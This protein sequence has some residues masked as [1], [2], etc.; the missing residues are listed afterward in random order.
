MSGMSNILCFRTHSTG[1]SI[2]PL[3]RVILL[4]IILS[5]V[6]VLTNTAYPSTA[7]AASS[8]TAILTY[9]YDISR[10]GQNPNETILNTSNVNA[11]Q[12]G[13]RVSYPV[14]GQIYAQPLFVPNLTVKGGTHNVVF[15]ATEHDSIYAFD[16]DQTRPRKPLW[17]F[18][19]INPPNVTPIPSSD[20]PGCGDIT[21]EIGITGTPVIDGNANILYVVVSTK[22]NGQH[23]QRLHALDITTGLELGQPVT[24]TASVKGKGIGSVHGHIT[25]DPLQQLQRPGLLSNGVIYIAW[26]S[27][28]DHDPYHGWVMGYNASTFQQTAV[29]NDT[30][31]GTEGGIWQSGAGISADSSGNIYFGTGNGTFDLSPHG[32]DAGDTILK[33]SPHNGLTRVDYFTPFNQSCL[34]QQDADLGSGGVPLL[35]TEGEMIEAGKEGRVYVVDQNNMSHYHTIQNPCNNQGRTDV[36]KIKQELPP[37][38]VVRLFSTPA[39]WNGSNGEFVYMAGA[40][41]KAKAYQLTNGLLS[42]SPTSE[43]SEVIGFPGSNLVISSNSTNP[44]TGIAWMLDPASILRAYDATNLANELY[45]SNQNPGRDGLSGYLVFTTPVVANG[46]VFVGTANSL[47]IFGLLS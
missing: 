18:S 43:S 10:S 38:T 13:K 46:E 17:H 9:K 28:C 26:G 6:S 32:R 42:T 31:N 8:I 12:F 35:P 1:L 7:H 45:N 2:T 14:D 15:V 30:P 19:F 22:E 44:G 47:S 3:R 24:I 20:I 25:F 4:L 39:Y 21:P 37:G 33:M 11:T 16:A 29:Y 36:D 40:G 5:G 23:F 41:D 34:E 27:H